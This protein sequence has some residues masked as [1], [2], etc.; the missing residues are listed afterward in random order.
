MPAHT[1]PQSAEAQPVLSRI[2]FVDTSIHDYR[3]IVDSI[4]VGIEIVLID[5]QADGVAQIA[6]ALS[7]R[8]GI[9][10]V[11]IFSHGSE[12]RVN[13]GTAH[14]S[15]DSIGAH[16]SALS[17][18]GAALATN[19]DIL[20][21][22]CD[23]GA[24]TRGIEL[25]DALALATGADIAASADLTGNAALGGNWVLERSSGAIEAGTP[26][27]DGAP[28]FGGTLA[29]VY[30]DGNEPGYY[31][32]QSISTQVDNVA[33]T[34]GVRDPNGQIGYNAEGLYAYADANGEDDVELLITVADGYSFDLGSL[35]VSA[36]APDMVGENRDITFTFT[37]ANGST[38][39]VSYTL[40]AD[41]T[42]LPLGGLSSAMNDVT[43]V[44]VSANRYAVF[45]NFEITDVKPI[46]PADTT[47]PVITGVSIPSQP[48]K[49]GSV[50]TATIT[51]AADSD[52]YTLGAGSTV[53]GYTLGNL[54]KVND[55]T[56]TATF[57]V[58][59]GSPD[60][61][62][63]A[64]IA[65]NLVLRDSANNASTAYTAPVVQGGDPIDANPPAGP[66]VQLS[67]AADSGW[68][69]SDGVTRVAQPALAGTAEAN[70]TVTI[71]IGGADVATGI[72]VDG[73]GKWSYTPATPL[74]D[75]TYAVKALATDAAGNVGGYGSTVTIRIDTAAPTATAVQV[76]FSS[77]TGS[78]A[79]D[80]VTNQPAQ[81]VAG[82]LSAALA[83]DERV[84]V[85]LDNGAHWQ[86]ATSTTG[87][88]SW[89][90][91]GQILVSS[92]TMRVKVVDQAGNDGPVAAF[93]YV[94]DTV[95]PT[96]SVGGI[97]LSADTGTSNTD[98]VTRVGAQ[99]VSATLSAPLAAGEVLYGSTNGGAVWTNISASVSGTALNWS[100]TLRDGSNALAFRVMDQAGNLGA[101]TEQTYT[102]DTIAPAASVTGVAFSADNGVSSTDL[103]TNVAAQT[104]S[105][106]LSADLANGERVMVS[107]DNGSSWTFAA[108][109]GARAWSLA[110][111]TLAGS[112]A[113][114]VQV[115]DAAGNTG[116]AVSRAYVLDTTAPTTVV[117]GIGIS[118]DSG[119]SSSDF[120][121]N[122][123]A[124]TVSATLSAALAAGDSL[125]A[126]AD[127]GAHWTDISAMVDGTSVTWTGVTLTPGAGTLQFR[128]SDLAGNA[129]P[130]S[131]RA[132]MLD[133]VAPGAQPV[134]LA[135]SV[136]S[137]AS[138]TD[139]VTNT[140]AQTLGGTLDRATDTGDAVRVS[141]DN[142]AHWSWAEHVAGSTA[143]SLGGQVLSHSD[144]VLVQVVDAAGN[145]GPTLSR[146]YVLDTTAPSA[147]VTSAVTG[148]GSAV[149]TA[150]SS[151]TGA[152]YLVE[153]SL[154][155]AGQADLDAAVLAGTATRADVAL[156]ATDTIIGTTGLAAGNYRVVAVDKAGNVGA[157]SSGAVTLLSAPD[158]VV[159]SVAFSNDSGP[160]SSDFITR[161]AAQDIS[162][163]LSAPIVAGERVEVS[164][165]GLVWQTADHV[166][167]STGWTLA[168]QVLSGSGTLQ[169]RVSNELVSSQVLTQA[170]VLDTVAPAAPG[171]PVLAA[172]S[173][174][175]VA[176]D[177]ITN[178]D[179]PVLSGTAEA[180]AQI[181]VYDNNGSTVIGTTRADADGAWQITATQLARGAHMVT[182][183]QTDV[184]GNVSDAGAALA[185]TIEGTAT[186]T[187]PTSPTT[188]PLVDGVPVQVAQV[189]LP[190]GVMGTAISVPIVTATRTET[191]GQSGVA[192]IPLA[193]AGA[194]TLLLA[195]LATGYGL[196]AS[197]ASVGMANG[198]EFLIASIKAATPN[199]APQ[200]QGHLTGNGEDFLGGLAATGSL[201]VQTVTPVSTGA[202]SGT[203]T[204]SGPGGSGNGAPSVALVIDAGGIGAGSTIALKQV[205]FAAVIGSAKVVA[206]GSK[207]VLSGDAAG[208][209]FTVGTG[210]AS[211]V[212]A[213]GGGDTLYVGAASAPAPA[214]A[215]GSAQAQA[216][217]MNVPSATTTLLH[218]GQDSDVAVFAGARA[219]YHV[220]Q[221]NGYLMVARVAAPDTKAMVVNVEKLEFG[222]GS[223]E[224]HNIAEM[225]ILA[226]M[227][228]TVLGRQA[229]VEGIAFWADGLQA[230]TSWGQHVL[231]FIESAESEA[232]HGAFNGGA[233][234]DLA[235][236]YAA[237]FDRAPDAHGMA[238]WKAALDSGVSLEQIAGEFVQSAEMVGHQRAALAWDFIV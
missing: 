89:T 202:A 138:A 233:D 101:V 9:E 173:D 92:D 164:F 3:S 16:A 65:V 196:S 169:V 67:A 183:R 174:S 63:G 194:T 30:F 212:F 83:A 143:W 43:S 182:V 1:P 42:L 210:D 167:G 238:F 125:L 74:A 222:D 158:A 156:A 191:S 129:G 10:A 237:L 154:A 87:S 6:A 172:A 37:R 11:H 75:G 78:S 140:A 80:L 24:G 226:G 25:L 96:I 31:A 68:S 40:S 12:G 230:G 115:T 231:D 130:V 93:A 85:S 119:S 151:E 52:S 50:V 103:I 71:N 64:D 163:T 113:I 198:L 223:V 38:G 18:I 201:L 110:G 175:G 88:S 48:M 219:D 166:V 34:F 224:V 118:A 94:L 134:G 137:G 23:V 91:P 8:S 229:D 195:Q 220:E 56:W 124:Q 235:I 77:D 228:Q 122:V 82:V 218:G 153:A 157:A 215:T 109:D 35:Q 203:L 128:V 178:V 145:A 199:H 155:I 5:G 29:S 17:T 112:G 20:L 116:P 62:A 190:G 216:H 69:S 36:D 4:D 49:I 176:G 60:L 148:V 126:S 97:A 192:D 57:T 232:S 161:I 217:A 206:T 81:T 95:A 227:Y 14:L 162:G 139:L 188:P 127:G 205:D 120:I 106:T 168:G 121:T 55:T 123:A 234:H 100:T 76:V 66:T 132:Y 211:E 98:F 225:D 2:A 171:A 7:G 26:F 170:Y 181:T 19:A 13:L 204:L 59:A 160:S 144:T 45:N 15:I 54:Q 152:V 39:S 22:G 107:L 114:R 27:A 159:A 200:D 141:L 41:N 142:G 51:V 213:G 149:T 86:Q 214:T 150:R 105:G 46:G 184:A 221:H 61:A 177:G 28:A 209:Q 53:G 165:D 136:D 117:G 189:M 33:F 32:Q 44:A 197:G 146:A 99:T 108:N 193:S 47:A 236:L 58:T 84:L 135:F 102:L 208:Q 73:S 21:Y 133:T 72:A 180:L 111:Q 104:I 179:R 70:S 186:P 79:S 147:S 131:I 207:V 187:P 185:L 90:L